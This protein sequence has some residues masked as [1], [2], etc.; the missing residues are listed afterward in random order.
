M[1]VI[2]LLFFLA[3]RMGSIYEQEQTVAAKTET[4]AILV[5]Y[6]TMVSISNCMGSDVRMA[7]G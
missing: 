5:C 6:L 2:L 7:D 1:S 4:G 3:V